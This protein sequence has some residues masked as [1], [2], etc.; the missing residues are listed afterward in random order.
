MVNCMS[1]YVVHTD[2]VQMVGGR[3]SEHTSS[4]ACDTTP[5]STS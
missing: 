4:C 3:R 2:G 1:C 5:S